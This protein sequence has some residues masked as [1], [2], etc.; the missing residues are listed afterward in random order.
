MSAGTT[1]TDDKATKQR[2]AYGLAMTRLREAHREEFNTFMAEEAEKLGVEWK[3][4]PTEE[5][6]AKA[7]LDAILASHPG[8]REQ[9]EAQP[10]DLSTDN[11]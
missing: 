5:Q 4:K 3:P 1:P 10:V 6:K 11:G 8:L 9:I 7:Q 2:R